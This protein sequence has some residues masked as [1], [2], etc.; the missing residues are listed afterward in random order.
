M[1]VSKITSKGQVTIPK[2]VRD[3]LNVDAAGKIEFTLLEDGKVMVTSRQ[4]S[5][6]ALFGILKHRKPDRTVS[7][8][9]MDEAV[10]ERRRKKLISFDRKLQK[11]FPDFVSGGKPADSSSH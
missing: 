11:A 5:A 6:T 7:I 3:F 9:D 10:R 4:T 1:I 2:K 8:E